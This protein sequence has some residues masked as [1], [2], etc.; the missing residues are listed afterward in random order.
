[1]SSV[2]ASGRG[3]QYTLY[4]Y[5]QYIYTLYNY[6]RPLRCP[7]LPSFLARDVQYIGV[8]SAIFSRVMS[9]VV[10]LNVTQVQTMFTLMERSSAI[11]QRPLKAPQLNC[12]RPVFPKL[13]TVPYSFRHSISCYVVV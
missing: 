9:N 3:E 12:I 5:I 1:M 7:E 6:I 8:A 2:H 13:F 10:L 4:N 11:G